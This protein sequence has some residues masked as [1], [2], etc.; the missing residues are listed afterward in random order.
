MIH[1]N[2]RDLLFLLLSIAA[3]AF[4]SCTSDLS[5][6]SND[7]DGEEVFDGDVL[8][9]LV[10]L[11]HLGG[12]STRATPN[13]TEARLTRIENYVDP[14]KFRVLVFNQDDEFLFES[15]TRWVKQLDPDIDHS[16]WSVSVPMYTYGNNYKS[17]YSWKWDEIRRQIT[18]G[19]FKIAILAN[20]PEVD[21][22]PEMSDNTTSAPFD[23]SGP[24]WTVKN[25][26]ASYALGETAKENVK[27]IFDLH[28]SQYDPIYENK[29]AP[30][31]NMNTQT[32]EVYWTENVYDFIMGK[33]ED[34]RPS[35]S[36]TSSWVDFDE[37]DNRGWNFRK[38]RLPDEEYPIPMYGVQEFAPLTGW[39]QGTMINLN[40]NTDKPVSLLRSVVKLELIV[41]RLASPKNG[42]TYPT[43]VVLFYSNIYARCEPM[44]VWTPT[45]Q[46]WEG[47]NGQAGLCDI[48]I[49]RGNLYQ[50]RITTAEDYASTNQNVK[51]HALE[52]FDRYQQRLAWYYGSWWQEGLWSFGDKVDSHLNKTDQFPQVFNPCIQR[53]VS[54]YVDPTYE[55]EKGY[56]YVVYTG[57]RNVNDPSALYRLGSDGSG[58]P[59]A[60]YWCVI[61]DTEGKRSLIGDG[62][63]AITY[64]F[65]I[66]DYSG[67]FGDAANVY[68]VSREGR[69]QSVTSNGVTS[70]KPSNS[71]RC[72]GGWS[73]HPTSPTYGANGTGMGEY[74]R[75]VQGYNNFDARSYSDETPY[76]QKD[77]P[78]PLVRNHVYT[79]TLASTKSATPDGIPFSVHLEEKHTR[80]I[81]FK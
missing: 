16:T 51:A 47:K 27:R 30:K 43:D 74:L 12:A 53:N 76:E 2:I 10:T 4:V 78:L 58:N 33:T 65:A 20:R 38:T 32:G 39:K 18:S 14:E 7:A 79:L 36:A 77:Y 31:N 9:F 81:N 37:R 67:E 24:D 19:P 73:N 25:S 8:K 63:G 56:H 6:P 44:N 49:I 22:F 68:N 61:Y 15:K 80:D 46:I 45:D 66:A 59:T 69:I 72:A 54:V 57:E 50:G 23:N 60:I 48:D 29:G 41:P 71:E 5:N 52:S 28:H 70:I 26:A 21:I 75:R 34:G 11:D 35:L 40:R 17:E 42:I 64:S 13:E 3:V 1:R 62:E 55:D